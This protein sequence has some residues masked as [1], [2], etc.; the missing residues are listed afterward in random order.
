MKKF[1][2]LLMVLAMTATSFAAT[3]AYNADD[4]P[5]V[6]TA[7]DVTV[8]TSTLYAWGQGTQSAT[9]NGG[10]G[11]GFPAGN[12]AYQGAIQTQNGRLYNH[13]YNH[14]TTPILDLSQPGTISTWISP[15]WNGTNQGGAPSSAGTYRGSVVVFGANEWSGPINVFLFANGV[16]APDQW[17]FHYDGGPGFVINAENHAS[18]LMTGDWTLGSWHHILVTWDNSTI[19]FG[20][21]GKVHTSAPLGTPTGNTAGGYYYGRGTGTANAIGGWDGW[22][23]DLVLDVGA[24]VPTAGGVYTMPSNPGEIPEPATIALLGLGALALL[25]KR[26]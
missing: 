17:V 7:W 24:T 18:D 5:S 12:S 4:G 13:N 26:N 14:A 9:G 2:V 11:Y 15:N 23:D 22:V 20:L 8:S 10:N 21:D 25:R 3:A 19:T 6:P 1:I 16:Q